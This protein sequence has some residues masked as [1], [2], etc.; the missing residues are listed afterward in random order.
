MNLRWTVADFAARSGVPASTLRYWDDIGLL[1][2][3]RLDNGHRRYGPDHQ[4]RLEMVRMCQALG[5][6]TEEVQLILDAP[7]PAVRAAYA[8]RTL[9]VVRER[10]EVLLVAVRVLEHVAVCQHPDAASCGAWMQSVMGPS[11]SRGNS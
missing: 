9:P 7:N 2:A 6:S 10:L 3:G 4:A 5:C 11:P 1:P 8:E